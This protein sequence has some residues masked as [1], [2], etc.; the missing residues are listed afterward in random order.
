M[1][2]LFPILSFGQGDTNGDGN[3]NLTDLFN[4]LDNWLSEYPDSVA[5]IEDFS[6]ILD[7]IETIF[8][9]MSAVTNGY[10]IFFP[11]GIGEPITVAVTEGDAY[12]VPLGKRLY[13]TQL[14][15]AGGNALI[16]DITISYNSNASNGSSLGVPLILNGEQ[17]FS[18]VGS[19]YSSFNGFL[20]NET[21]ALEALTVNINNEP[22]VVEEGKKLY[23]TNLYSS[24]AIV[25][26]DNSIPIASQ[27]GNNNGNHLGLPII[28][29]EGQ[30]L[31]RNPNITTGT[32][33]FNGYLVD[34]DY[35]SSAT[36]SS[37]SNSISSPAIMDYTSGYSQHDDCDYINS[38]SVGT[39]LHNPL[40][41]SS[42]IIVGG[43]ECGSSLESLVAGSS[44]N[45]VTLGPRDFLGCFSVNDTIVVDA[46]HT[47]SPSGS[48]EYL[49]CFGD[50]I[51]NF[52]PNSLSNFDNPLG[53]PCE[54]CEGY[55]YMNYDFD[56]PYGI[57]DP[58]VNLLL[59]GENQAQ[60]TLIPGKIYGYLTGAVGYNIEVS[61]E[62]L[63]FQHPD[64]V[65]LIEL[66]EI[67]QGSDTWQ[68][69]NYYTHFSQYGVRFYP[70]GKQLQSF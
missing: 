42:G 47:W 46:L 16:D 62:G 29:N 41:G 33:S 59:S 43:I 6:N 18:R 20:V 14:Y 3:V 26:I 63:I 51:E 57:E 19:A 23:V 9:N 55:T 37:G 70:F 34:E 1:L 39:I 52:D 32:A 66:W 21:T 15:T 68:V 28:L 65:N 50:Y 4:V 67:A 35:F 31:V 27:S 54:I 17:Q 48:K 45:P 24:G 49:Y 38:L 61:P 22:Y 30:Q 64:L 60:R 12:I 10:N 40:L 8:G 58:S 7:S 5:T 56:F 44:G 36:S 13:I 2:L 69:T 11:E 25:F 53:T